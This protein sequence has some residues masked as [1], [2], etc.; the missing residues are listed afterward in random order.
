M[1]LYYILK[2]RKVIVTPEPAETP[3]LVMEPNTQETKNQQQI[4]AVAVENQETAFVF[5]NLREATR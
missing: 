4:F 5:G 2:E 1:E 3:L